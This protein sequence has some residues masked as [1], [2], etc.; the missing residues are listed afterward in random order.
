MALV[1]SRFVGS[2]RGGLLEQARIG[3]EPWRAAAR[4]GM[5]VQ[6]PP[7]WIENELAGI[8]LGDERL[9]RRC[10]QVLERLAAD[11]EASINAACQGWAET[12]AAYE[13][14]K[15]KRVDEH[16]V[17]APH[18]AA[19]L[20]RM[21]AHPVVLVVQD[22]TEL[23]Y[24]RKYRVVE[25]AGPLN[26]DYR[27]GFLDHVHVAFTPQRLCLGAVGMD[28]WA[29]NDKTFGQGK[30]R[31]FEP[32]EEKESFRWLEGYRLSCGLAEELPHTQIVS[33]AD[34]EADIYECFLEAQRA[35]PPRRA[36]WIIRARENRSL[37]QRDPEA[38]RTCFRKLFEA[39]AASPVL[40]KRTLQI[41]KSAKRKARKTRVT[42]RAQ[43][44]RLKAPYRPDARLPE[45]EV[46]V[47]L[48]RE[49]N[50]PPGEE[51]LEWLLLTSLPIESLKHALRVIDYYACR[52]QIEVFFRVFKTGC[53]VEEI[54]L[55]TAARL[56]PCLALYKI[57]AWRVLYVTMLGRGAPDL[58]CDVLFT[59]EEWKSAWTICS[60]R[61]LPKQAPPLKEFVPML[62][63]LGGYNARTH[64]APPGP[65]ALWIAIRRM[66]D[67]ALAWQS[68]GPDREKY[69]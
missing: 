31:K 40:G 53:K 25:G 1:G 33:I 69:V 55:E 68:F 67:F 52:W 34:R 29:R 4:N 57:V 37:P 28:L 7:E 43:R 44:I 16:K 32:I 64:D 11:P 27:R 62:A 39:I 5:L 49:E 38:G 36:E 46:N 30:A 45:V 13:F 15:H 42:I 63:E 9:N 61:P 60:D 56:R 26:D 51:P 54:Q 23:D 22:T 21:K 65:K 3:A 24:T 50:P 19:T 20:Q 18:R 35:G 48:V 41:P 66:G 58:P 10:G 6:H 8:D 14:F 17:L 12:H 59:D 47:V 2:K